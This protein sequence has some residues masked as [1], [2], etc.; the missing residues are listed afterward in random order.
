MGTLER[1]CVIAI[2]PW[3]VVAAI[4]TRPIYGDVLAV[5]ESSRIILIR[6]DRPLTYV[7]LTA[8]Y[9][10]AFA[11]IMGSTFAGKFANI[12]CNL[13]SLSENEA[14]ML[15]IKAHPREEGRLA[16]TGEVSQN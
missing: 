2:E 14:N 1:V 3:E 9:F 5:D 13:Y 16:F 10:V 12:S 8:Q 15:G 6:L 4:G 11:R 7:G